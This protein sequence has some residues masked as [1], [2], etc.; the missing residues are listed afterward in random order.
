MATSGTLDPA[1]LVPP[2]VTG[3]VLSRAADVEL[4][5]FDV[6]GVLTE[7]ALHYGPNGEET[8][9]FNTLDGHGIKMLQSAGVVVAIISGRESKALGKRAGDLGIHH[10]YMG[11]ADKGI[12][13]QTLLDDVGVSPDRCGGIGDDVVDLPYLSRCG[14]SVAVPDAPPYLKAQV[15]YVT[16]ARAGHGAAREFCDIILH[17]KGKL[18]ALVAGYSA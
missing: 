11:V 6:D 5:V 16:Q 9:V 1:T 15:H 2:G 12:K 14:F 3:N 17:A 18:A 7:G 4:A 10:L 13:F 8:K